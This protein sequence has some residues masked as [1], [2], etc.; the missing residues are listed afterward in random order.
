MSIF[1]LFS[2]KKH[3]IISRHF[4]KKTKIKILDIGCCRG[5]F[6]NGLPSNRFKK[7]GVEIN[8]QVAKIAS[9]SGLNIIT[10][11][12]NQID[13]K[14]KKFDCITMW[15]VFEHLPNPSKTIQQISKILKPNG[16][17]IFT[18][19]NSNSIGFKYGHKNFFHLDS[20]R[21]LFIPNEKSLEKLL[22]Q[23]DLTKI[24]FK[25][26]FLE[27]PLDLFWSIRKSN[28][29]Y[30]IYPFYLIFKIFSP[31]LLQVTATKP[32]KLNKTK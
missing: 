32:A 9:L 6:L 22:Q 2:Q 13:F 29:K 23:S 24:T 1:G 16:L 12:I 7:F 20:P 10:G 19:P 3:L 4:S 27:Y 31:E 8:P 18:V 21:H 5:E 15:H 11:D 17:L 25:N 28:I 30:I 26:P 14:T